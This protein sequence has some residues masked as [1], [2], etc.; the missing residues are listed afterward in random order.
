MNYKEYSGIGKR[1]TAIIDISSAQ[2][3]N[4]HT[5]GKLQW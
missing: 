1:L 4:S 2:I 5:S 3:A